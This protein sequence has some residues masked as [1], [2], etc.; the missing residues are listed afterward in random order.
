MTVSWASSTPT[1]LSLGAAHCSRHDSLCPLLSETQII[2]HWIARGVWVHMDSDHPESSQDRLQAWRRTAVSQEGR[3]C[4]APGTL[5]RTFHGPVLTS[6]M[7]SYADL[8]VPKTK[9]AKQGGR[10]GPFASDSAPLP[11]SRPASLNP[12]VAATQSALAVPRDRTWLASPESFSC[13]I[14]TRVVS[15]LH[16]RLLIS[17]VFPPGWPAALRPCLLQWEMT[18][19]LDSGAA[20]FAA[21]SAAQ[22]ASCGLPTA[23]FPSTPGP[24]AMALTLPTLSVAAKSLA[25]PLLPARRAAAFSSGCSRPR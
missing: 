12:K 5:E 3:P 1:C 9:D 6:Q 8:T 13:S 21:T 2:A 4:L 7:L 10:C 25:L 23:P 22:S 15:A 14:E 11:E 20:L 18:L 24:R 19:P 17:L 16:P